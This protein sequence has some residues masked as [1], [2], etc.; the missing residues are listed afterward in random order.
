M[1]NVIDFKRRSSRDEEWITYR[2][3][4]LA[5]AK[6]ANIDLKHAARVLD[7]HHQEFD[8]LLDSLDEALVFSWESEIKIPEPYYSQVEVF[9]NAFGKHV[10]ETM[11]SRLSFRLGTEFA[12]DS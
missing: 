9:G 10:Y 3:Q 5:G 6:E 1:S 2:K 7:D 4:V 11:I 8:D 12:R